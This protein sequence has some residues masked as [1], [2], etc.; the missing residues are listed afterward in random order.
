MHRIGLV[1]FCLCL[2]FSFAQPVKA[3]NTEERMP[4]RVLYLEFPPYYYTNSVGEPDGFLLKKADELFRHAG[5][6]PNYISV[7]A[8]QILMEMHGLNPICSI[9]WFRTPSREK[10]AKFSRTFYQNRPLQALFVKENESYFYSK[11]TLRELIDDRTLTL[12]KLEGYSFGPVVDHLLKEENAKM[13]IVVG[14][15]PQLVR[16]LAEGRFSYVLVAPEE[17]D[18]LIEKN[19]FSPAFFHHKEFIDIP[20]G[21]TRH[22]MFS[23]G[24]ADEVIVRLNQAI[25]NAEKTSYNNL[26]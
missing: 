1:A 18:T 24:M 8:K 22:L 20:A 15:H 2:V 4:L 6:A 19:H 17:I 3:E 16:L 7:P 11:D 5:I 13:R 14:G 21:N 12:G 26:L 23:R 10:Y 25:E 9:G